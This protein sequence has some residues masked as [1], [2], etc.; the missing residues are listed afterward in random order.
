[1]TIVTGSREVV[2]LEEVRLKEVLQRT[3]VLSAIYATNSFTSANNAQRNLD[4]ENHP[5]GFV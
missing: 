4:I 5:T 1:M 3:V 2:T